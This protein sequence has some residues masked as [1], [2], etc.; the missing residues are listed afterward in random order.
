MT[1]KEIKVKIKIEDFTQLLNSGIFQI[2]SEDLKYIKSQV[3]IK[4]IFKDSIISVS[5][6]NLDNSLKT[7]LNN[8]SL[9]FQLC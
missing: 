8:H 1:K 9:I 6:E 2:D 5:K 4:P 3:H 7:T